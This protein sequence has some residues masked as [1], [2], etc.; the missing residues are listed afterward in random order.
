MAAGRATGLDDVALAPQLLAGELDDAAPAALEAAARALAQGAPR[1]ART[2][3]LAA[4]ACG[5]R[6]AAAA[7]LLV[8]RAATRLGEYGEARAA[9]LRAA[10]AL[11]GDDAIQARLAAAA[12][13]QRAGDLATAEHELETLADEAI[14]GRAA[15]VAGARA[16]LLVARGRHDEAL[17]IVAP[18]VAAPAADAA[19]PDD[20]GRLACVEAAGLASL[21]RGALD[22]ADACFARLASAAHAAGD[23]ARAGRAAALAAM[24]AQ[25]R[26]DAERATG[27]QRE[28]AA[29]A[30]AAGDFHGAAVAELNVAS[31]L[32]SRGEHG[33]AL[34]IM[35]RAMAALDG[36]GAVAERA[37]AE[38]NRG[39]SLLAVGDVEGAGAAAARAVA[40]A[41]DGN[42]GVAVFARLLQGDV[43]W[44]RGDTDGARAAYR[45]ARDQAE[46]QGEQARASVGCALAEQAI[47]DRDATAARAHADAAAAHATSSDE[48]ARLAAIRAA[49]AVLDGVGLAEAVRLA[50]A[51]ARAA[52]ADGRGDRAWRTLLVAAEG[53]AAL[54]EPARVASLVREAR[55]QRAEV[56]AATPAPWRGRLDDDDDARRLAAL[57]PSPAV[58]TLPAPRGPMPPDPALE[59]TRVRRLL[60]LS[61]RLNS[62]HSLERL[63]DDVIDA[64]IEM[65]DAERGFLLLR[66]PDGELEAVVARNFAAGALDDAAGKVSPISIAL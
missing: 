65:T 59:L 58:P 11:D 35:G 66:Q 57:A 4:A 32:A 26:G 36:F 31:A 12:A 52:R 2:L 51:Q 9:G 17:A 43:A 5:A 60:A 45:Q 22:R 6:W 63:L 7:D 55:A 25:Q 13:A 47:R 8:A 20:A 33:E 21:Y 56:I 48:R 30:R 23:G 24:V 3:A 64:A 16:R 18:F 14:G 53:A 27:L 42:P 38:F 10:A 46:G 44:R 19:G 61:R 1:R 15:E 41:G 50:E 34:A 49:A 54:A 40:L 62:E 29:V 28:A 37:A 39:S